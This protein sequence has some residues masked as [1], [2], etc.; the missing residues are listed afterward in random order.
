M[1]LLIIGPPGAGKG[2]L[3]LEICSRFDLRHLST[4]DMFRRNIEKQTELG[5]LAA[6]FIDKGSLVPDR[7]TNAM[8]EEQLRA[9]PPGQGFLIDGYPRTLEQARALD[10]VLAALGLALDA[11]IQVQVDDARI[12]KRLLDR[13]VCPAC[14]QS[15]HLVNKRPLRADL[16]DSCGEGLIRRKDD[17]AETIA[18]RLEV[19]HEATQPLIAYY[20]KRGLIEGVDNNAGMAQAAEE[21][22]RLLRNRTEKL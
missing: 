1:R 16:C 10:E 19:Y 4:G 6:E 5:R 17:T 9:L 12:V 22:C 14:G 2:T 11:V 15:Y 18:R 13:R 8:V 7:V 20:E 21:A 3:A